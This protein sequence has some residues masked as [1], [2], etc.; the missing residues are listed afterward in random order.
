MAK[1]FASLPILCL[2]LCFLVLVFNEGNLG[3]ALEQA[4]GQRL[5]IV[6]VFSWH[7]RQNPKG[8]Q[9]SSEKEQQ[10]SIHTTREK[11]IM[12]PPETLEQQRQEASIAIST[13]IST[14]ASRAE[15]NRG[16]PTITRDRVRLGEGEGGEWVFKLF[17]RTIVKYSRSSAVITNPDSSLALQ[18]SNSEL[19]YFNL[20]RLEA[21]NSFIKNSNGIH[22]VATRYNSSQCLHHLPHFLTL[23]ATAAAAV[24]SGLLRR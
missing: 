6:G 18:I 19:P 22:L 14:T 2:C 5:E 1:S 13:A 24:T 15:Q 17:E 20:K 8:S 21:P 12:H 23:C 16:R 9:K 7:C 11:M 10:H 3:F 4:S